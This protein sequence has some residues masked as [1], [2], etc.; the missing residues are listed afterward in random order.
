MRRHPNPNQRYPWALWT[1]GDE[2]K[3]QRGQDFLIPLGLMRNYLYRRAGDM[4]LRVKTSTWYDGFND[5]EGLIFTFYG[6]PKV[7]PMADLAEFAKE[8]SEGPDEPDR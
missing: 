1:N 2:H 7:D 5:Y 6:H 4:G 3:I 8:R